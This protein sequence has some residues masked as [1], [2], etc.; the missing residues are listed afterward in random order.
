MERQFVIR[1]KIRHHIL[2][3]TQQFEFEKKYLRITQIMAIFL[4]L[5]VKFVK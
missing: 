4:F 2:N 1:D 3:Q 5:L